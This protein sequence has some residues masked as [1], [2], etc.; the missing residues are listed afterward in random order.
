VDAS[1]ELIIAALNRLRTTP[2]VTAFVGQHIYDR[3]PEKQDGAPNV[4]FPY[5]SVGPS[6]AVPDDFDC[7]GGEEITFQLDV[8]TNG[9]NEAYGSV[10]CRKVSAAVKRALHD[11]ELSLSVNAL[12]TL[13]L[14]AMRILTD[15][16]PAI[17]H[18][19]LTF[20]ATVEIL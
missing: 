6:S 19:A 1:L 4:P 11:A 10:Q 17:H 12:V 2:A 3:V 9:A 5:I 16:N 20:T 8:W 14:E 7:V 15:P 18:G 13:Q